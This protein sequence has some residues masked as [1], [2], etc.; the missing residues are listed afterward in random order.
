VKLEFMPMI[1]RIVGLV[2]MALSIAS[3]N[4]QTELG[5]AAKPRRDRN[6]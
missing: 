2:V 6:R 3:A 4:G 1:F 5:E